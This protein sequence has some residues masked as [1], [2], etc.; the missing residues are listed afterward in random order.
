MRRVIEV[1]REGEWRIVKLAKSEEVKSLGK[2]VSSHFF[3]VNKTA[4]LIFLHLFPL[5]FLKTIIL[6]FIVLFLKHFSLSR[7]ALLYL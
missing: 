3:P 6:P 5:F 7:A 1:R 4:T 2:Y